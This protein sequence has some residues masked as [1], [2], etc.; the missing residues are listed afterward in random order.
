MLAICLNVSQ[1]VRFLIVRCKL[2]SLE[3]QEKIPFLFRAG[4]T[5]WN[6][7][8]Y[9]LKGTQQPFPLSKEDSL[10]PSCSQCLFLY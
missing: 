7:M 3:W 9:D 4:F 6:F 2:Q 5:Q 1:V 10:L 8:L